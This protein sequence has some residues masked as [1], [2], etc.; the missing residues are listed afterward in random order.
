M[1]EVEPPSQLDL[2]LKSN[3]LEV[4][5]PSHSYVLEAEYLRVL[6]P[7][8]E[9]RGHGGQ[10]PVGKCRIKLI[11]VE[12]VG[13]YAI[14]LIF[15]DGHDSGLYTWEYLQALCKN[16]DANWVEYLAKLRAQNA[17]RDSDVQVLR[18]D[19]TLG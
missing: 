3:V 10:L 6:S 1:S 8:A 18:I 11:K 4:T 2:R 9:V 15:D 14:K 16:R 5:Y 13:H 7:S 12:P 17:N 19:S